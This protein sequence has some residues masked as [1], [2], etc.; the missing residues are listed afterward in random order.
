MV[1]MLINDA[2]DV[3]SPWNAPRRKSCIA[4]S[5]EPDDSRICKLLTPG[6]SPKA[7]SPEPSLSSSLY[8][9][10]TQ[11]ALFGV[12]CFNFSLAEIW[13]E[14]YEILQF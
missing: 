9:A 12:W 3:V 6:H 11:Q 5:L 10:T 8:A 1:A 4:L 13:I 7:Q 14:H 2:D